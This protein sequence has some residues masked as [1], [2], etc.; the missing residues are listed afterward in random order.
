M[1]ST[2]DALFNLV[3]IPLAFHELCV[4]IMIELNSSN[5]SRSRHRFHL[6]FSRAT[7]RIIVAVSAR[8]P[9]SVCQCRL[10]RDGYSLSKVFQNEKGEKE[11]TVLSSSA[12]QAASFLNE[13]GRSLCRIVTAPVP[14]DDDNNNN[15]TTVATKQQQ[16]LNSTESNL[17]LRIPSSSDQGRQPEPNGHDRTRF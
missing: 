12:N 7:I 4:S 13:L 8:P 1:N 16:L 5:R 17:L 10:M 14:D 15:S 9:L 11:V 2:V 6:N 3:A